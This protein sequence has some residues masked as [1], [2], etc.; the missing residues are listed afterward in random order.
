MHAVLRYI[1]TSDNTLYGYTYPSIHGNIPQLSMARVWQEYLAKS[2]V[3]CGNTVAITTVGVAA[4]AVRGKALR[5]GS[6]Q[7]STEFHESERK[8]LKDQQKLQQTKAPH[9]SFT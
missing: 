9:T 6:L 3:I 8:I 7:D 1:L 5:K 2:S 4:K